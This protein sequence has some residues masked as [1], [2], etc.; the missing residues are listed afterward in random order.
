MT[1]KSN[2]RPI[3]NGPFMSRLNSVSNFIFQKILSNLGPLFSGWTVFMVNGLKLESK[4]TRFT[5][6]PK[7]GVSKL[8]SKKKYQNRKEPFTSKWKGFGLALF[9]RQIRLYR[10]PTELN[11]FM[12]CVDHM[13]EFHQI[14]WIAKYVQNFMPTHPFSS[15]LI[16]QL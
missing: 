14:W 3:L 10:I 13:S 11:L 8:I 2:W 7:V 1:K 15:W 9:I 5:L 16:I 12:V 6:K 4:I